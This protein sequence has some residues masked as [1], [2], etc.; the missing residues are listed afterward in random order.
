MEL[1]SEM[2]WLY[3]QCD[4]LLHPLDQRLRST[5]SKSRENQNSQM[6]SRGH[7]AAPLLFVEDEGSM[8]DCCQEASSSLGGDV[9]H[10]QQETEDEADKAQG[11]NEND[12]GWE[13]PDETMFTG[14]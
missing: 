2:R 4:Q 13:E 11:D 1:V 12:N 5:Y 7:V 9:L 8:P 10:A 14:L 6:T 3:R